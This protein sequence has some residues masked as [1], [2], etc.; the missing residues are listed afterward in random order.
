LLDGDP[1]LNLRA[2]P[3]A[4]FRLDLLLGVNAECEPLL[5]E[6]GRSVAEQVHRRTHGVGGLVGRLF[7]GLQLGPG[8]A[9]VKLLCGRGLQR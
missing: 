8:R 4:A 7:L 2:F 9:E 1:L 3:Y 5:A 6:G